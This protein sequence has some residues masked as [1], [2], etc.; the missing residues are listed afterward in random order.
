MSYKSKI[1]VLVSLGF[2]LEAF[3]EE[4]ASK[5]IQVVGMVQLT[6]DLRS[7]FPCSL[8]VPPLIRSRAAYIPPLSPSVFRLAIASLSHSQSL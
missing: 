7:P 6:L 3:R 2:Y 5:L 4:Y 1:K 8:S